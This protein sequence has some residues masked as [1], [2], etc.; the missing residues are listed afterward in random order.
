MGIIRKIIETIQA[1]QNILQLIKLHV[2]R[3]IHSDRMCVEA[4]YKIYT[5]EKLNL[6]NPQTFTEKTQWLKVYDHNPLYHKLV[7]KAEVKEYVKKIIGEKYIIPTYG[8]WD[9]FN[10]I[11]FNSLPQKFVLK[12]TNGG[13]ST[14]VVICKDKSSFNKNVAK[15]LLEKSMS[16]D[17]YRKMGEWVYKDIRPR[18]I[19]EELLELPDNSSLNDY[20]FWCFNGEPKIL[21]YASERFNSTKQPPFFDFYDMELK[22]LPVRSKGHHNSTTEITIFPEFEDMKKLASKLSSGLPFVRVDFYD[23]CGKIYFG[24]LTFYHDSGFVPFE[25]EEWNIKF[26]KML[27]LP[28]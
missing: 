1:P 5:K 11:D 28:K 22:R 6:N 13:G 18:I 10:D 21:F 23:V 19:A 27:N 2:A 7:D 26:G 17:I 8:V 16:Y 12:T 14:G 9:S 3:C 24:E 15:Q 20:K 25:P 4:L